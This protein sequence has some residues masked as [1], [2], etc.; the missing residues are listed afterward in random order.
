MTSL[1]LHHLLRRIL[2]ATQEV[3]HVKCTETGPQKVLTE[4]VVAVVAEVARPFPQQTTSGK[5]VPRT[6]GQYCASHSS[7]LLQR[8]Q[9]NLPKHL[10]QLKTSRTK[11]LVLKRHPGFCVAGGG[12]HVY[13]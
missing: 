7:F 13:R 12:V 6:N 4:G 9:D 2:G 5:V 10:T 3:R 11:A 1:C 8:V